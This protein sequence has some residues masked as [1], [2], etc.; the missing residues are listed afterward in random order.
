MTLRTGPPSTRARPHRSQAP[1]W[2]ASA[3]AVVCA[4]TPA[5]VAAQGASGGPPAREAAGPTGQPDPR[6]ARFRS[7]VVRVDSRVVSGAI[8][9]ESLGTRRT[10]SGVIIDAQTVL[11]IGYLVLE[12]DSVEIIAAS[13]QR[14]P[15]NVAGYD[16]ATGFGL[17][18][19]LVPLDGTPIAL[20]DSDR[21]AVRETVLTQG[22]GEELATELYVVSRKPFTG[23]W[24]YLIERPIYTF[25]PVNNWSGSAL[26]DESG[27]L[28]GIGSLIVNDAASERS[29]VPGNLFV[30]VN[31]LKPI[32]SDLIA[33][34]R[35]S[36]PVQPWL[37]LGTEEVQGHLMVARVSRGGPARD[38]G[39]DR[40]DI[41]LAVDGERVSG[42]ADF[43]RRL[44][45]LGPAGTE[46]TLK[47]L[48]QGTVRDIRL[49]SI[50][51]AEVLAK[52]SGV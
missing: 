9:A 13:G 2:A 34:G 46:I 38:A 36:G 20:G 44:W 24:E 28:I 47:V 30:P 45:R 5:A 22:H 10:G 26:F 39:I 50:D 48:Q 35:R 41:V 32:L 27:K 49:R 12:A 1:L 6:L 43:Y 21:V 16:H 4:L 15:A 11:T 31:I 29:G 40:G 7:T 33:N 8:T 25:P 51:R 37:G 3:F 42:Q 52:P 17:L 19:A 18:R 14:V 23:S